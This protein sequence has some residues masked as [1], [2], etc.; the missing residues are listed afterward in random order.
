MTA[1]GEGRHHC[2]GGR[3]P[4]AGRL[5]RTAGVEVI[6]DQIIVEQHGRSWA[7]RH[8]EGFL[9]FTHSLEEPLLIAQD[10]VDWIDTHGAG[11]ATI[12]TERR[13]FAPPAARRPAYRL[14]GTRS[15]T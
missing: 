11:P 15:K 12:I 9:G 3:D 7:V 6:M 2:M 8:N 13:S 4:T 1:D 10:L 14:D 5:A